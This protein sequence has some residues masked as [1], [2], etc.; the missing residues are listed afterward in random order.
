MTNSRVDW[1]SFVVNLFSQRNILVFEKQYPFLSSCVLFSPSPELSES[2]KVKFE[3]IKWRKKKYWI[4][5]NRFKEEE[6]RYLFFFFGSG[7]GVVVRV[8]LRRL[9]LRYNFTTILWSYIFFLR[10]LTQKKVKVYIYLTYL[11]EKNLCVAFFL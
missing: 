4:V 8:F 11:I 10:S 1:V 2:F 9:L 5:A 6:K 3:E 7:G